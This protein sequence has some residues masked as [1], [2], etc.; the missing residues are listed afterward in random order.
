MINIMLIPTFF[1]FRLPLLCQW[2]GNPEHI[3]YQHPYIV[4][5]DPHFIEVRHVDTVSFT[6]SRL[7]FHFL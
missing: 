6:K 7:V 3:I 2:E 1:Q 4:A 5:F